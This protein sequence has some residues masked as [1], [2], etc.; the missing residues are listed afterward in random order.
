MQFYFAPLEGITGCL[1]RNAFHEV[2]GEGIT[3]YFTPFIATAGEGKVKKRFLKD[4][5]PENNQGL[6]VVPQLLSNNA[7]DFENLC[8]HLKAFG[9]E[10]VNL[11]LGCPSGT[12]VAKGRGAGFLG[13]KELLREFLDRI[14]EEPVMEIS[15]KTRIGMENPDEFAELLE[16]YNQYPLKELIIHPR[17]RK[18]FYGNKP[19]MTVFES[20]LKES[21]NPVC[22]NG[23]IF[24]TKDYTEFKEHYPNA[25]CMMLG[26]GV[27][28][29]PALFREIRGGKSLT[30]E[31]LVSF[32][33]RLYTDY[34]KEMG[35]DKNTLFKMKELWNYWQYLFL[36]NGQEKAVEKYLKQI[37]KTQRGT[38][39]LSLAEALFRE[40]ELIPG[41][42]FRMQGK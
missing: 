15:V 23:D 5:L 42:G 7:K 31:E 16:L 9:Y 22:Y 34:R 14:F 2:F 40:C 12:V 26:R 8:R 39:Y 3:K 21:K 20:A 19:N 30:K 17:V 32:H 27:L 29:N 13:K 38:E 18:D 11:N 41:A 33:R 1:Y 24:T 10:E 6:P 36:G 35:E 25:E 4:V 28:A 37:R